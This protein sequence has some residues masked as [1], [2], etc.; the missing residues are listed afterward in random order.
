[1]VCG[2][3]K[4]TVGQ[5]RS[6]QQAAHER[7]LATHV[8]SGEEHEFPSRQRQVIPYA[9]GTTAAAAAATIATAAATV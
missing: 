7:R 6:T 3:P 5:Q 8:G 1:M 4:A 2:H 9:A